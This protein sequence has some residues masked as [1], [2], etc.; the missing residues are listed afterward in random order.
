[1]VNAVT[2]DM[3]IIVGAGCESMEAR[4]KNILG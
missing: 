1:M 4:W 2:E 3:V